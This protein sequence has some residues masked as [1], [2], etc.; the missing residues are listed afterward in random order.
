ML[1]NI[2]VLTPLAQ[3]QLAIGVLFKQH[4]PALT[5]IPAATAEGLA[6][7]DG[8]TLRHSRLVAFTS[9]TI[10]P[11]QTLDRLGFGAYNFHPG[12]PEYPGWAPAHF[13]LYQRATVFGA[14][15]HV[16]TERVDAGPIVGV[17]TFAVPKGVSIRELEQIA[18]ARLA[19]L[20]WRLAKQLALQEQP[21]AVLP[22]GW[23]DKRSTRRMYES[24]CEIP[25][26]ISQ[27]ELARRI[28]AFHDDFRGIYP[29]LTLHG[30]KFRML[31]EEQPGGNASAA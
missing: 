31:R 4:N 9:G 26:D 12:P 2:I 21:L 22:I 6:S 8:E 16:M 24:M 13:A 5:I 14:T 15:A 11:Q 25:I 1:K 27:E 23:G 17:E 7:L 29:T 28:G 19:Y 30:I 20:L 18:Y 3:Q 10:V